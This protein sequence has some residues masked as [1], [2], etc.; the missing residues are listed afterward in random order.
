MDP[1]YGLTTVFTRGILLTSL[2]WWSFFLPSGDAS[3]PRQ[4]MMLAAEKN[5]TPETDIP[6][7]S[8]Y[9]LRKGGKPPTFLFF[10]DGIGTRKILF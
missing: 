5:P 4:P 2:N 8:R 3:M 7:E 10:S 6:Q 9:V 1:T